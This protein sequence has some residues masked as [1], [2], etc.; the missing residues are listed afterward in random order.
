MIEFLEQRRKAILAF[1]IPLLGGFIAIPEYNLRSILGVI[2]T[3]IIAATGV[4]QVP[5]KPLL[6]SVGAHAKE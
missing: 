5:N 1:V 4:H 3:A 6:P 2:L